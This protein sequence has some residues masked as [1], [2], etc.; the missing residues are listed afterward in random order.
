MDYDIVDM[1]HKKV[2]ALVLI[3]LV[4]ATVLAI[5]LW[6]QLGPRHA[7]ELTGAQIKIGDIKYSVE[8]A[9]TAASQVRG[10]SGRE[11]LPNKGGMLFIF[12]RP[13]LR[14]FWMYK[15]KFPID[16]IWIKEG[17]VIGFEK[18]AP[19]PTGLAPASFNSPM[20]A[21]MVLEVAAGTVEDDKISIGATAQLLR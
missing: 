12:N 7:Q 4:A 17:R 8:L 3:I 1:I 9:E 10:L 21:D 16:I 13:E 15:M 11:S 5:S 19:V 14:M 20:P 6:L 18:N 2:I